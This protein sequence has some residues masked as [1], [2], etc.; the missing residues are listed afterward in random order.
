MSHESK[1]IGSTLCPIP[2]SCIHNQTLM[3][4]SNKAAKSA[5][6]EALT[7][8]AILFV[9]LKEASI[10]RHRKN[11]R[12]TDALPSQRHHMDA[13]DVEVKQ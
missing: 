11:K 10:T 7:P 12:A 4:G 8:P 13:M 5:P 3:L 9:L 2:G 6:R 1:R